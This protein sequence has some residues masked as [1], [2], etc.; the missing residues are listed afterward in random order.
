MKN[1]IK[2]NIGAFT[3]TD[4]FID[5]NFNEIEKIYV[6]YGLND[7]LKENSLFGWNGKNYTYKRIKLLREPTIKFNRFYFVMKKG[8]LEFLNFLEEKDNGKFIVD[9]LNS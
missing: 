3:K 4:D 2:L 6:S 9:E 8:G 1:F 7:R 5:E